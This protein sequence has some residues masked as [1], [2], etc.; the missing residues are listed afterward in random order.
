MATGNI[1]GKANV[2]TKVA[3]Y[4]GLE[5]DTAVVSVNNLDK[6]IAVDVKSAPYSLNVILNSLEERNIEYDGSESYTIDLA[7]LT[8]ADEDFETFTDSHLDKLFRKET[9]GNLIG[10]PYFVTKEEKEP[11]SA[12]VDIT[13]ADLTNNSAVP[14]A[15][16][17]DCFNDDL[18]PFIGSTDNWLNIYCN[19]YQVTE[20]EDTTTLVNALRLG[21]NN[22][23]GSFTLNL[24]FTVS[25]I[26][27]GASK[28]AGWNNQEQTIGN[29]DSTAQ[30]FVNGIEVPIGEE[31]DDFTVNFPAPTSVI[32][33]E[34]R[35]S[36]G[37]KG[38]RVW[39]NYISSGEGGTVFSSKQLATTDDIDTVESKIVPMSVIDNRI[40]ELIIDK[41]DKSNTPRIF[42]CGAYWDELTF[43]SEFVQNLKPGDI[44]YN[45][46][47]N[48]VMFVT[49]VY[50]LGEGRDGSL[51]LTSIDEFEAVYQKNIDDG[52]FYFSHSHNK[53]FQLYLHD[54]TLTCSL[55]DSGET[56]YIRFKIVSTKSSEFG[57]DE[58]NQ[59]WV[60]PGWDNCIS[61]LCAQALNNEYLLNGIQLFEDDNYKSVL[62]D[63]TIYI[64]GLDQYIAIEY[65]G[66]I[67]VYRNND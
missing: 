60:L 22:N 13:L 44:I 3:L 19:L 29:Y 26:I 52:I 11:T 6:T 20:D 42:E 64:D 17:F 15:K 49:I 7:P 51:T 54:F 62:S 30:L 35:R 28:Y 43:T 58:D 5:T 16:F 59:E 39:I 61:C 4:D 53:K 21:S 27:I 1:I 25:S 45:N 38:G 66:P 65:H 10:A 47:T 37:S 18:T 2:A 57:Y 55:V 8:F 9:S 67:M 24:N 33:F 40:R 12:S 32:A 41:A 46:E 14:Q 50:D 63:G 36:S 48:S 34:N 56:K 23:T 31:F